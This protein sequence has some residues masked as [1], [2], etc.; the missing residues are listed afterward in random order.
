MSLSESGK[1]TGGYAVSQREARDYVFCILMAL[2]WVI[3]WALYMRRA[4]SILS[5]KIREIV[6]NMQKALY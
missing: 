5:L 1:T 6:K 2:Y 4:V 3:Q